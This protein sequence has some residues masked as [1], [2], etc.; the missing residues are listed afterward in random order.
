MDR[1]LLVIDVQKGFDQ[2][3]W[4]IRNN[5]AC[6]ENIALLLAA[7]RK[8]GSPI[9]HVQH[10]STEALSPLR[11]GQE[12]CQFKEIARPINGELIETKNVNSAFIGTG[13]LDYLKGRAIPQVVLCGLTTD[14]CVSTT[15]RMA[16][17]LGFDCLVAADATATFNR[18]GFDGKE[19][20]AQEIYETALASLHGEF[21]NVVATRELLTILEG[22]G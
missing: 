20:S 1:A 16:A 13:L 4:G 8:C 10:L 21:A 11:P 22:E 7:F 14:H 12:G 18:T 2:P 3:Y 15:T 6:E 9:V 17:N 5:P 19:F